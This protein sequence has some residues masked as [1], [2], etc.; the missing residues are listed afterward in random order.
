MGLLPSIRQRSTWCIW[1]AWFGIWIARGVKAE[2]RVETGDAADAIVGAVKRN[3][4]DLIAMTTHAR[5]GVGR[6]LLGSV[7][8][9]VMGRAS[10]PVLVVRP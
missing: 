4:I 9:A 2:F 6:W 8:D 5:Q 10:T 3:Q 7:T 1:S